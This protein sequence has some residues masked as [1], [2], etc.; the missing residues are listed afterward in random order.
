MGWNWGLIGIG[1]I[2]DANSDVYPHYT[3]GVAYE[4]LPG[5]A[6]IFEYVMTPDAPAGDES[7]QDHLRL[8]LSISF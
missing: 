5:L 1:A 6:S 8:A 7:L 3:F 2:T 4:V